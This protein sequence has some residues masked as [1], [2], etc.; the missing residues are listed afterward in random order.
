MALSA[1]NDALQIANEENLSIPVRLSLLCALRSALCA[2]CSVLPFSSHLYPHRF[3]AIQRNLCTY[4]LTGP[5]SVHQSRFY[6]LTCG[7]TDP[8]GICAV[9]FVLHRTERERERER[10]TDR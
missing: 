5:N 3:E 7:L 8:F 10:E 9:C 6:C 2:L 4:V 1:S